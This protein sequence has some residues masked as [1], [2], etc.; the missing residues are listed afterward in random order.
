MKLKSTIVRLIFYFN[1]ALRV[2]ALSMFKVFIFNLTDKSSS[3]SVSE[4]LKANCPSLEISFS[5]FIDDFFLFE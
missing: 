1:N 5:E 4:L 2:H 3:I